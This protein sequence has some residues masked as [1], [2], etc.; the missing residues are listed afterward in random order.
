MVWSRGTKD[1]KTRGSRYID[2][3]KEK[4]ADRQIKTDEDG[5]RYIRGK[6]REGATRSDS[7]TATCRSLRS[8]LSTHVDLLVLVETG[9]LRKISMCTL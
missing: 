1:T 7:L 5:Y 6:E 9:R 3:V 2:G 8:A 4:Q